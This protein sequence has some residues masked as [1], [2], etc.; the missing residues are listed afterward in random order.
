MAEVTQ[1]NGRRGINWRAVGWGGAVALLAVP[2]VAMRFTREVNWTT[3]DFIFAALLF[4]LVGL[5]FEL[6]VRTSSNRAWRAGA[7]LAVLASFLLVW[8]NA[9]VGMIGNEDNPYN[10]LF[11]GVIPV[12]LTGALL[13]RFRAPGM[14]VTMAVAGI[15]QAMIAAGGLSTDPRGAVLSG[16][17]AGTWFLSAILFHIA[18]RTDP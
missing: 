5:A 4:G 8:V 18:G 17:M 3:G 13:A 16:L 14:A 11:L 10:L 2:F 9:A 12:A 7:A 6:A 1:T 15:A